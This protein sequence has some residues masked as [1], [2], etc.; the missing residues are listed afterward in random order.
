MLDQMSA[1]VLILHPSA[2]QLSKIPKKSYTKWHCLEYITT[3]VFIVLYLTGKV[4]PIIYETQDIND[5]R[6]HLEKASPL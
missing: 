5:Y 1:H 4:F 2:V 3:F 6:A